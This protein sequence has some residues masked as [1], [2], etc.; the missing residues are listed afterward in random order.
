MF[1][2][3]EFHFHCL[4]DTKREWSIGF[5]LCNLG[6]LYSVAYITTTAL[7]FLQTSNRRVRI[8]FCYGELQKLCKPQYYPSQLPQHQLQAS[9]CL[10]EFPQGHASPQHPQGQRMGK[11][12]LT[13]D[14]A[15]LSAGNCS[16]LALLQFKCHFI[17]GMLGDCSAS[18]KLL[19]TISF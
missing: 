16:G 1:I 15:I 4:L 10:L 18:L 6:N 12:V 9:N 5:V 3:M 7:A 14:S 2:D 11:W 8:I 13:K 17:C 19:H